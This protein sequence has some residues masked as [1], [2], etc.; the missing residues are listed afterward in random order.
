[1]SGESHTNYRPTNVTIWH[2]NIYDVSKR[3]KICKAC[4]R[5]KNLDIAHNRL[6]IVGHA[7]YTHVQAVVCQQP[8]LIRCQTER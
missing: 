2:L 5:T 8:M 7:E 4:I 6:T 1:M 3:S